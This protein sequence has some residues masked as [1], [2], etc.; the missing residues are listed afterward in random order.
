MPNKEEG[1][2]LSDIIRKNADGKTS[3]EICA[4]CQKYSNGSFKIDQVSVNAVLD[5]LVSQREV[6]KTH[7]G[8]YFNRS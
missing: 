5:H 1:L 3:L 8:L 4:E 7:Y 6:L 2:T